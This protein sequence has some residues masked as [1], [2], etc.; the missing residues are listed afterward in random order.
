MQRLTCNGRRKRD[1]YP[2]D[3][4]ANSTNKRNL[5]VRSQYLDARSE[6]Q[7]SS[8]SLYHSVDTQPHEIFDEE[9]ILAFIAALDNVCETNETGWTHEKASWALVAKRR[10][11]QSGSDGHSTEISTFDLFSHF[12]STLRNHLR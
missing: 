12:N 4:I 8:S 6:L 2:H 9:N 5:D 11:R 1:L 7:S 10:R 3:Q